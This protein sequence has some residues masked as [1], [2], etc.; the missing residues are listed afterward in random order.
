MFLGGSTIGRYL[1]REIATAVVFVLIAF[2][3]LFAFF[4]FINELDDV[5]RAGYSLAAAAIYVLLT[6]PSRT[7]E[8]MPIAT[9]IGSV[10][11]LAQLAAHSEFTAMRA[12]GLSR[13]RALGEL[14]RLG[15]WLA[16][17]TALV[18]EA[19]APPAERLAQEL[20]LSSLGSAVGGQLRSGLWI[21]DSLRDPAGDVQR[22][23]FVNVGEL[24]PDATLRR[25]RILEFDQQMRLSEVVKAEKG[26][27]SGP[28]AWELTGVTTTLYH[29]VES[30]EPLPLLR[31]ER[32]SAESRTWTS[33]L[34]PALLSVLMVMPERMSAINLFNYIRHLRENQQNTELHEIAFWKKVVYPLAVIVMMALALPFAYL[35]SRAG[36]IGYKVFAGIMLGVAFHFLNG[37]FSHLGLLNTWSPLL[38]VSIPSIVAF[39][40]AVG[41]LRWVDRT[42]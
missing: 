15:A 37:L 26:R 29:P 7:Y 40:V 33:E 32:A 42:R 22:I 30:Q 2:L 31:T 38:A 11:A 20:R 25:V 27:F 16:V 24:M 39:V 21:R 12:S 6:L 4:D 19:L 18:G 8:V 1:A 35:Q 17:F 34:T 9:L 5:G 28:G 3:A 13:T 36:G 23:R 41:L 10:Y 14:I